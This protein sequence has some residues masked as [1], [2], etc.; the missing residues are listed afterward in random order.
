MRLSIERAA[1]RRLNDMPPKAREA[2]RRKLDA[3]AAEPFNREL[4]DGPFQA[5]GKDC[6]KVRQG[7]WRAIYK[8]DRKAQEVR[9]QIVETRGGVYR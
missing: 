6:F 3:I 9:V 8:I 7:D 1:A 2:L 5:G 4:N